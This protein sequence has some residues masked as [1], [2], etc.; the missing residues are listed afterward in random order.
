MSGE[1]VEIGHSWQTEMAS[2]VTSRSAESMAGVAEARLEAMDRVEELLGI[3][4]VALTSTLAGTI[5]RKMSV[6]AI[7][8][9][10][11][12]ARLYDVALNASTPPA[13]ITPKVKSTVAGGGGGGGSHCA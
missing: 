12:R 1:T 3:E 2:T 5:E 9:I 13:T 4:K 11:A 10:C 6:G 8:T 7:F